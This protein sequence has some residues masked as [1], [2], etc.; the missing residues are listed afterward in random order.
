MSTDNENSFACRDDARAVSESYRKMADTV[1]PDRLNDAVLR[2]AR[3]ATVGKQYWWSSLLMGPLSFAATLLL[4][5]AIVLGSYDFQQA[6]SNQSPTIE[7]SDAV[8][9]GT[10]NVMEQMN[11][12]SNSPNQRPTN[13]ASFRD[14][15]VAESTKKSSICPI[16]Q[17]NNATSWMQCINDIQRQ[18]DLDAAEREHAL[19]RKHFPDFDTMS[20]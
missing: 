16:F 1:V 18:G 13:T 8:R 15:A 10:E 2:Q 20:R 3:E 4:G 11:R 19:L 17:T 14:Q 5:V 12:A 6:D 9:T 7:I